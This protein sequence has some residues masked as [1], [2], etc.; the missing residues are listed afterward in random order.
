M[1]VEGASAGPTTAPLSRPVAWAAPLVTAGIAFAA[2]AATAARTITW[3]DGG[4][5]PLAA[6]TLGIPGAPGSLLLTLLGALVSRLPL[7]HPV[8]FRLNLFAAL[9]SATLAG[10][11][12]WLGARLATPEDRTPGPIEQ[13]AGAL[14]GLTFAFAVTPW[15]FAVQFT[16]YGLSALW[17]AL[18]LAAA[19][20][21]WRR[22]EGSAGHWRLFVLFLLF[23]LDWSVHRT[24]TLLLPAVLL[25][26][27]F[28]VPASPSR[29]RDAA[30]AAS[31]LAL[32]LA[33]HLLL[34][35]MAARRPAYMVEDT[36]TW[37][38]WWSYVTIGQKGGGFL[39]KLFPRTA[40]LF[41][42]QFADW[43]KFLEHNLSP[44][45]FL[46]AILAA[47]GWL[48][49]VRQHPR[50]A[51]GL[52]VF[53]LC[54]GPGAVLYFNL[55]HGYMRPIDRHYLPS[56]VILAPW[57]A[58]GAAGI[59]R[60]ATRLPGRAVTA[61]AIALV[62]ALG[63]LAAWRANLAACDFSRVRFAETFARNLL[64]PLPA[65]AILLTN[66]DNDSFPPWY[67]QQAE[68][69]RRDVTVINVPLANTGPCVARLRRDDPDLAGLLAGDSLPTVLD[70]REAGDAVATV[71]EPRTGLGLPPGT[72]PPDTVRFHPTGMLYGQDRVVLDLLRLTRWK[73]PVFLACTVDA[74]NL[75]WLRPYA[76]PDGLAFRIIPS[77]DPA[78]RDIEHERAQLFERVSYAGIAD[79]AVRMDV[80][81]GA[82]CR[83][84]M[85]A[86]IQ[87]AMAQSE[88]GRDREALATV[89]L[90]EARVPPARLGQDPA[91]IAGLRARIEARAAAGL[92]HAP[93]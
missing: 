92:R 11:L 65:R 45:L 52:M 28:R 50:R 61:S 79:P 32:G 74:G 66:G 27:L 81:S 51:L 73:R 47:L 30:A 6:V 90:L 16:P 17:T 75:P 60:G 2:Y 80:D 33:F 58:V 15:T 62:M 42:V 8:A 25:W 19:L 9:V 87:L 3:W 49:I 53:F 4:S 12:A 7:V 82:I 86:L 36:S 44:A 63:P 85:A 64:E 88:R 46:P 5:Y 71:V 70:G 1:E 34:I 23:G 43:L 48:L 39:V 18:I 93:D 10:V 13:L 22:P 37:S 20:A 55:P 76:R 77:N 24:N 21:W 59:L 14:A 69:V 57:I 68:G 91:L 40:D 84:Y 89:S 67:L 83:N 26:I 35:P 78:I 31:G 72:A 38:G 29:V 54:A 41:S 56:L